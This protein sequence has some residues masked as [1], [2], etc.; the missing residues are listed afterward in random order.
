MLYGACDLTFGLQQFLR[1]GRM[2]ASSGNPEKAG[3]PFPE[4]MDKKTFVIM[5]RKGEK[6]HGNKTQKRSAAPVR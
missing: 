1:I 4:L 3:G 6:G 2:S 5:E